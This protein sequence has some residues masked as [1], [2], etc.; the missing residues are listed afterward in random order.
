MLFVRPVILVLVGILADR[1]RITLW[2]LISFVIS[3]LGGVLFASGIVDT[4]SNLLFFISVSIFA[5][6][7]YAVRALYFGVMKQGQIP[8][9]LAGA[10]IGI[11][12]LIGYTPDIFVGSAMGYFL[13]ESPGS[14]GH[15]NVFWML[16]GFSLIGGIAAYRY[17]VR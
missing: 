7:V 3:I 4:S 2:L 14:E 17:F 9:A 1:S 13:D 5:T 11:I 16:S 10:A 6:G 8:L 12:S 15:Q